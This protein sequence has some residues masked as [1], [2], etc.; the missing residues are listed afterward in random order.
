MLTP[1]WPVGHPL[2]L[3]LQGSKV[4]SV[5]PVVISSSGRLHRYCHFSMP[6]NI[7][8]KHLPASQLHGRVATTVVG[9]QM[10]SV[11]SLVEQQ[12]SAVPASRCAPQAG[13]V[14]VFISTL[15]GRIQDGDDQ[16]ASGAPAGTGGQCACS[17]R[18][19]SQPAWAMGTQAAG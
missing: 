7:S 18:A 11:L 10:R 15:F 1:F 9:T 4:N 19:G 12:T 8:T 3:P 5:A 16:V 2:P 6:T 13:E 17:K 14:A